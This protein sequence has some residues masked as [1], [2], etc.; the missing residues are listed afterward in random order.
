[1]AAP[2][3]LKLLIPPPKTNAS[4]KAPMI[5]DAAVLDIGKIERIRATPDRYWAT[6]DRK[7][8]EAVDIATIT[9]VRP[10]KCP[11]RNCGS[12]T[13]FAK[14][15]GAANHTP[16]TRQAAVQPSENQIAATPH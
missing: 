9:A 1:M 11:S 8:P 13:S 3:L 6:R 5:S 16:S 2:S 14:R 15:R 4:I 10:P 7:E 12:V